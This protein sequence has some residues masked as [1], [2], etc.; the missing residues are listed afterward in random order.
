MPSLLA[1]ASPG[2]Y[3]VFN[4]FLHFS[5]HIGWVETKTSM[6]DWLKVYLIEVGRSGGLFST[7][8][9][10]VCAYGTQNALLTNGLKCFLLNSCM[11]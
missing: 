7:E 10:K 8:V 3:L 11:K 9:E 6:K 4:G 2:T 5:W 1:R